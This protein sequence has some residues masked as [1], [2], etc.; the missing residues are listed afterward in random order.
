MMSQPYYSKQDCLHHYKWGDNC[1]SWCFV[2]RDE[3]S[4]KQELMPPATTEQLHYHAQATQFFFI[5]KGSATM[6]IDDH[7]IVLIAQQ[8]VEVK[9]GML[10]SIGNF[11]QTDLEFLLY[12]HPSA[13]NDRINCE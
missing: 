11:A 8:G 7:E 4:I 12:S 6:L 9:P 10:H 3:L 1:D 13:K 5:L 2:D